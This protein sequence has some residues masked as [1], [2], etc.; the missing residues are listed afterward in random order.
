MVVVSWRVKFIEA[1]RAADWLRKQVFLLHISRGRHS[2]DADPR[3]KSLDPSAFERPRACVR[4]AWDLVFEYDTTSTLNE[5]VRTYLN[6]LTYFQ[7][8][9][10]PLSSLSLTV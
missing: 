7:A 1:P 6:H 9:L 5:P 2:P 3:G 4:M 10:S 8:T